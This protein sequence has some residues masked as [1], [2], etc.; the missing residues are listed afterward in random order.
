[1]DDTSSNI[2]AL[3]T[4]QVW[5]TGSSNAYCQYFYHSN[6]DENNYSLTHVRG[7]SGSSSNRPYMN[8]SG[9]YPRWLM[10]HSGSYPASITVQVYGGN[11]AVYY[12]NGGNEFGA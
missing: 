12:R 2:S 6:S 1:M 8:L 10:N 3:I 5:G 9:K 7:N 4:V 11:E